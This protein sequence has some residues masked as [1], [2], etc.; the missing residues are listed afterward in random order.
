LTEH[1]RNDVPV[2]ALQ[3]SG[4]YG[5]KS[6]HASV[7]AMTN[8]YLERI[9]EVQPNGPYNILVYCFSATVGNEMAAILSK[10]GEE[11]NLI[12]M[13][14]MTAPAILNTPRRLKIRVLTFVNRLFRS[15]LLTIKNAVL[16]KYHVWQTRFKGR[17][18]KDEE[19]KELEQLRLNLMTLSR[20]YQWKPYTGKT[21]LILTKKDH[22]SL[23]K[24]IVRSWK[25]LSSTD[26]KIV[27][28]QGT[29]FDLFQDDAIKHTAAAIE[30]CI[31]L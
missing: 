24:E 22:S 12:V 16:V 9:R 14:T 25:E 2:Y 6:M 7:A 29:H 5:D 1:L 28:I 27:N 26:L 19:S 8:D 15:P 21:S 30:K 4:V 13:D 11:I 23:N 31:V 3:P 18:E 10:C 17:F 20:S